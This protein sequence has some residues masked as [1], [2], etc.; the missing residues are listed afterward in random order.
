MKYIVK[1]GSIYS[2]DGKIVENAGFL[3]T[4]DKDDKNTVLLHKVGDYEL[5]ANVHFPRFQKATH[6]FDFD[7]VCFG[8]SNADTGGLQLSKED[9]VKIMNHMLNCTGSK[10]IKEVAH[11]IQDE[12]SLLLDKAFQSIIKNN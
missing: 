2:P 8:F 9:Q 4:V 12:D 3:L 1:Y 11:A 10:W 5:I 7:V 6:I